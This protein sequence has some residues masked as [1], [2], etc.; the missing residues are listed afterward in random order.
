MRVGMNE[1]A[2]NSVRRYTHARFSNN[3]LA[4]LDHSRT[5]LSLSLPRSGPSKLAS[6]SHPE[7]VQI[8]NDLI[9]RLNGDAGQG[10]GD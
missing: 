4:F 9:S 3:Q 5:S 1:L 6:I 8:S 2:I 7:R 10:L